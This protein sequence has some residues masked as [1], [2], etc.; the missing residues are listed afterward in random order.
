MFLL[1][2]LLRLCLFLWI[3]VGYSGLAGMRLS[4]FL[5]LI[6]CVT[7]V[8]SSCSVFFFGFSFFSSSFSFLSSLSHCCCC[9]LT[10]SQDLC[11]AFTVNSRAFLSWTGLPRVWP[12]G[13]G[14]PVGVWVVDEWVD[15]FGFGLY[16]YVQYLNLY[17]Y[18]STCLY[19]DIYKSLLIYIVIL[20][21]VEVTCDTCML[22]VLVDDPCGSL[23]ACVMCV[24]VC[25]CDRCCGWGMISLGVLK[26]LS[27]DK[28][29]TPALE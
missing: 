28:T 18:L 6:F 25:D 16:N 17:L 11:R 21:Y 8:P 5:F 27:I 14:E 23:S 24:C 9:C 1:L 2:S 13:A 7:C 3:L 20:H 29:R 26:P 15:A 12:S 10:H 4:F 22:P 19:F